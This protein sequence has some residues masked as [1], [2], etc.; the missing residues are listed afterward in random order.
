MI[1]AKDVIKTIKGHKWSVDGNKSLDCVDV[2]KEAAHLYYPHKTLTE[3]GI[4]GNGN[5][6]LWN[7]N[8]KYWTRI[9]NDVHNAHQLPKEGDIMCFDHTPFPGYTNKYENPYGHTGVCISANVSGYH[10]LMQESGTGLAAFDQYKPWKYRHC[11]GWLRP[12]RPKSVYYVV[13]ARDTLSK[14][15]RAAHTTVSKLASLNKIK[16]VNLI[17]I[18]QKLRL[19]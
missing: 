16:N 10:L 3:L 14:I 8:P 11:Q 2:V 6:I 1:S 5:Q 19:K 13:K 12:K 18:G 7:A 4:H 15:A 9:V 17:R